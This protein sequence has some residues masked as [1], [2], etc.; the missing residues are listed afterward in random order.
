MRFENLFERIGGHVTVEAVIDDFY[1]A[2]AID[3]SLRSVYPEDLRPGR[4]KLKLFFEQWLG[5]EPLY[6]AKYG[7]PRLRRRHFPFIIAEEHAISWLKHMRA[8]LIAQEI[9]ADDLAAIWERLE[10]LAYHMVNNKDD[11][12]R[13]PFP[14]DALPH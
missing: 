2:V 10:P 7:H 11:I 8:A 13:D 1:A 9:P 4:E 5:G 12:P 6:S 14:D 3:R